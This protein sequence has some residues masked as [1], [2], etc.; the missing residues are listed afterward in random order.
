[1]PMGSPLKVTMPSDLF[2]IDPRVIKARALLSRLRT[3][4]ARPALH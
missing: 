2:A 1:M 4:A 3:E